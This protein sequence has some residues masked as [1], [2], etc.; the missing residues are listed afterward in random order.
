MP[1]CSC[2]CTTASFRAILKLNKYYKNSLLMLHLLQQ[3][4]LE[5]INPLANITNAKRKNQA[6]WKPD[7]SKETLKLRKME[8]YAICKKHF[9]TANLF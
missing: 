6:P 9:H 4:L 5:I 3:S 7:L 1:A 2:T 8:E